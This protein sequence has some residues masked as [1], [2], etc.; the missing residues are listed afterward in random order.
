[1]NIPLRLT[2]A[3]DSLNKYFSVLY[4]LLFLLHVSI[5][6]V[7]NYFC[8][9]VDCMISIVV[10]I[11]RVYLYTDSVLYCCMFFKISRVYLYTDSVLYCCMYKSRCT[12]INGILLVFY[13]HEFG[14]VI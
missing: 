11:S 5:C 7:C 10:K 12:F 13:V 6:R 9:L 8:V 2:R 1:M 14:I 4:V 3:Y